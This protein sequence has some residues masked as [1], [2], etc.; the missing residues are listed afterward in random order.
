MGAMA[1]CINCGT[2][3]KR[4]P[5]KCG[6]CG[7]VPRSDEEKAKSFM[8]SSAYEVDGDLRAKTNDELQV[9]GQQIAA[10]QYSFNEQEVQSVMVAAR[11]ALDVPASRLLLDAVKWVAPAL[12]LLGLIFW[13]GRSRLD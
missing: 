13:L 12:L 3:K 11:G 5:D 7:F 2:V 1:I 6:N 10:G 4:P 9:I 8:L